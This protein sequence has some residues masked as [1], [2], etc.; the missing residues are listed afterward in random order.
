MTALLPGS[1][2]HLSS[3][4]FIHRAIAKKADQKHGKEGPNQ[5][6]SLQN[7]FPSFS[8]SSCTGTSSA[9]SIAEKCSFPIQVILVRPFEEEHFE[10]W[11][12]DWNFFQVSPVQSL[13]INL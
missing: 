1:S 13:M 10:G 7:Q 9:Q 5:P 8:K 12:S 11:K 4:K 3:S 2:G 6:V